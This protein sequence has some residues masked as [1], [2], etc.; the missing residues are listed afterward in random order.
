MHRRFANPVALVQNAGGGADDLLHVRLDA[1]V[2]L[3]E[4]AVDYVVKAGD[5][6]RGQ[7]GSDTV[8]PADLIAQLPR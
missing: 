6:Q 5:R 3:F 2:D 4:G 8:V 7:I 1:R